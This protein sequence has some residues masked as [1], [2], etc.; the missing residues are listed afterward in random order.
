MENVVIASPRL[1][2]EAS[3]ELRERDNQITQA[4]WDEAEAALMTFFYELQKSTTGLDCIQ[5]MKQSRAER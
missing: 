1:R 4:A 3:Q 2:A 5:Y